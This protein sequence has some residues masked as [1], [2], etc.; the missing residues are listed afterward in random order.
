MLSVTL[1]PSLE[2]RLAALAKR[3]GLTDSDLARE[4]LEASLEDRED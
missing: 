2:Q 4:L 1:D 3:L